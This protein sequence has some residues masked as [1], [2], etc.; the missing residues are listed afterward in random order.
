M[1]RIIHGNTAPHGAVFLVVGAFESSPTLAACRAQERG[2]RNNPS[3]GGEARRSPN[4]AAL[5][6]KKKQPDAQP[7]CF[8][9][10]LLYF[11]MMFAA[12]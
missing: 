10:L 3:G 4:V 6:A 8:Q 9:I 1:M 11:S 2:L 12:T 7:D 5:W